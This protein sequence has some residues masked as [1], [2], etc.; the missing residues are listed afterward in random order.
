M[1]ASGELPSGMGLLTNWSEVAV[2]KA[3]LPPRKDELGAQLS[4]FTNDS[5]YH[6]GKGEGHG[7]RHFTCGQY[8]EGYWKND[9]PEGPGKLLTKANSGYDGEWQGGKVSKAGIGIFLCRRSYQHELHL[10]FLLLTPHL[11]HAEF[12]LTPSRR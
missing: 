3:G 6:G 4:F 11:P 5:H 2:E 10:F 1:R 7:R 8:Q 9:E 12:S